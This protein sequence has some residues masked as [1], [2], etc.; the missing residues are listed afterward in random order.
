MLI[1]LSLLLAI[2]FNSVFIKK[3]FNFADTN[4][5]LSIFHNIS[6]LEELIL[7]F[8]FFIVLPSLGFYYLFRKLKFEQKLQNMKNA[9][10]I[11]TIIL[12]LIVAF[13]TI[14]LVLQGI[15]SRGELTTLISL[16]FAF[17]VSPIMILLFIIVLGM[18]IYRL[19]FF[20][21]LRNTESGSE[22]ALKVYGKV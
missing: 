22:I 12:T 6:S 21:N 7:I 1:V 15:D 11:L 3:I 10:T 13:I 20:H 16:L 17:Y 5:D 18:I 19:D 4:F 2:V 8:S 14:N 9:K